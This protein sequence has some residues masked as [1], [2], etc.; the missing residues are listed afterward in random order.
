MWMAIAAFFHQRRALAWTSRTRF[1]SL[2]A[3]RCGSRDEARGA[4]SQERGACSWERG[5]WNGERRACFGDRLS[6]LNGHEHDA[7]ARAVDGGLR[8]LGKRSRGNGVRGQVE[9]VGRRRHGFVGW[10]LGRGERQRSVVR[11][12]EQRPVDQRGQREQRDRNQLL[13]GRGAGRRSV[14]QRGQRRQ[15]RQRRQRGIVQRKRRRRTDFEQRVFELQRRREQRCGELEQRR[16]LR[17]PPRV[18][19]ARLS[20]QHH[21]HRRERRGHAPALRRDHRRSRARRSG[22]DL[23]HAPQPVRDRRVHLG[24]KPAGLRDVR[25][26]QLAER[27]EHLPEPRQRS[28][29]KASHP[30]P[31]CRAPS[32]SL[33]A[34]RR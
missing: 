12:P 5:A 18:Q 25:D 34:S 32:S 1:R 10:R 20:G 11:E 6:P 4:C 33:A 9:R 22:S 2:S 8:L 15:R 27:D 24:G 29:D 23:G 28:H 13:L 3:M 7:C 16:Q 30:S 19:R 31:T 21:R 14:D 26:A 17:R